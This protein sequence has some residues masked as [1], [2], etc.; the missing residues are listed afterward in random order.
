[1]SQLR[2]AI[3]KE[4]GEGREKVVLQYTQEQILERIQARTKE[5]L[6]A[7]EGVFKRS[8]NKREVSE[9]IAGAFAGLVTEFQQ[10]TVKL[11]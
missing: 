5:N 10:E 1:M 6:S 4:I 8:W 9:A 2:F 3:L 11:P 7:S